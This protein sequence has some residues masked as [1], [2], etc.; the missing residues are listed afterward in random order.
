M[1]VILIFLFVVTLAIFVFRTVAYMSFRGDFDKKCTREEMAKNFKDHESDF[2]DLITFFKDN[3]P[4]QPGYSI[5]LRQHGE[6][7]SL[8][9]IPGEIVTAEK[10]VIGAKDPTVDSQ[11]L[12]SV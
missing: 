4:Q 7:V 11:D 1:K 10:K 12:D 2:L 5:S 8:Y 6:K 9:L 3:I